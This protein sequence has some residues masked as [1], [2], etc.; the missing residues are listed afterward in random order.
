MCKLRVIMAAKPAIISEEEWVNIKKMSDVR[1]KGQLMKEGYDKETVSAIVREELLEMY[2][3]CVVERKG[4]EA[5]IQKEEADRR[6]REV[7]EEAE[8]KDREVKEEAER[9]TREELKRQELE[10]AKVKLEREEARRQ[11]EIAL[12]REE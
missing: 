8:R 5:K 6:A 7:K 1:L 4:R 11:E 3:E 2:V 9:K 12:R 10:L